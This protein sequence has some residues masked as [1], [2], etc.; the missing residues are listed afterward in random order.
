M[1]LYANAAL[2]RALKSFAGAVVLVTH[3]RHLVRSVVEGAPILPP[4]EMP[5]DDE[6]EGEES[7]EED[8]AA[9]PGR[10]FMVG[11]GQLKLMSSVDAYVA[12]VEK[13]VRKKALA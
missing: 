6:S 1:D 11:K 3:D 4:S 12:L 7:E 9:E 5:E 8:A 2:L 13:R 10:T